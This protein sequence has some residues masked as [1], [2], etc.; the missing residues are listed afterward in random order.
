M[1]WNPLDRWRAKPGESPPPAASPASAASA[2]ASP[3][4]PAAPQ[5]PRAGSTLTEALQSVAGKGPNPPLAVLQ[6]MCESWIRAGQIDEEILRGALSKVAEKVETVFLGHFLVDEEVIAEDDLLYT[7]SRICR[8]PCYNITQYEI[9][10]KA[11]ATVPGEAARKHGILP[12]DRLGRILTVAVSN[13]FLALEA[14]GVPGNIDVKK[15]LCKREEIRTHLD[16]YY[17]QDLARIPSPVEAVPGAKDQDT[18]T[19]LPA[20]RE[21]AGQKTTVR[22]PAY[23]GAPQE[24]RV[25]IPAYKPAGAAQPAPLVPAAAQPHPPSNA[26]PVNGNGKLEALFDE[27]TRRTEPGAQLAALRIA[28]E[29]LEFY[30]RQ[31]KG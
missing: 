16:I 3:R 2:E 30:V 24:A 1:G 31:G 23:E 25:N 28:P 17:P 8:I 15:V 11:L 12:V 20:Y 5:P 27:W 6:Q 26:R 9:N 19:R 13:P 18:T 10:A 4:K 21:D 14:L 7:L 22:M 29:E